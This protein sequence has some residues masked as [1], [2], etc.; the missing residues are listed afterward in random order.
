MFY[1]GIGVTF[2]LQ[3]NIMGLQLHQQ[4]ICSLILHN[5]ANL[6]LERIKQN[7]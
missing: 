4:F 1:E 6:R 3:F 5:Q 7:L 2:E